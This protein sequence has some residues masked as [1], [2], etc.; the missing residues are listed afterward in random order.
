MNEGSAG[1]LTESVRMIERTRFTDKNESRK[2]KTKT[3]Y[4]DTEGRRHIKFCGN[5]GGKLRR[6]RSVPV[7]AGQVGVLDWA[8]DRFVEFVPVYEQAIVASRAGFL[9]FSL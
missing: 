8:A 7:D 5:R 6:T 3:D 2:A 1:I 4:T 9:H